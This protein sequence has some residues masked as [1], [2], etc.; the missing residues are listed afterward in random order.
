MADIKLIDFSPENEEKNLKSYYESLA[1]R[2]LYSGQV[3]NLLLSAIS[4]QSSLN[5]ERFNLAL[6]QLLLRHAE[7]IFLDLFGE[8]LGCPRLKAEKGFDTLKIT[9]YE[10]YSTDKIVPAGTE[11]ETNDGS[12]VFVTDEDVTIQAGQTEAQV[13]ITSVLGG[14]VLNSYGAGTIT[15]LIQNFEYIESVEN[16]NGVSGASDE[17]NDD[18]YRERLMLAPEKFSTAG[19]E[20]AYRYWA[21]SAHK[22][23]ADVTVTSPSAGVVDLYILTKNGTAD[24]TMLNL[25]NE[26]VSAEKIRPLTDKVVVHSAVKSDFTLDSSLVITREA[27]YNL[28]EQAVRGTLNQYFADLKQRLKKEVVLS[29]IIS[30][31][32]K[33]EGVYDY[34]IS[35][36]ASNLPA[37]ITK[38][39]NGSIGELTIKRAEQ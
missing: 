13:G 9:T 24:Q 18:S 23:I 39:H 27:D 6:S 20:E 15:S 16:L 3:D 26:K 35:A 38:F 7:G 33:V 25:V 31:V 17:E 28:T 2:K 11:I 32:K 22:D 8:L 19:P 36:P 21:L 30:A 1:D 34:S 12:Y 37:D 29:D 4:Y 10:A 14:A 5:L